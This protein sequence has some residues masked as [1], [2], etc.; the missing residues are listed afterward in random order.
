MKLF[1]VL[2][3][4]TL[5]AC[6][7]L[8]EVERLEKVQQQTQRKIAWLEHEPDRVE[9]WGSYKN[10]CSEAGWMRW[11]PHAKHCRVN[12]YNRV[13]ERFDWDFM[14]KCTKGDLAT[15]S[16]CE[17]RLSAR[18]TWNWRAKSGNN[19]ICVGKGCA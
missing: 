13:P 9:K 1:L 10:W 3:L 18:N 7:P 14:Y 11:G 4:A 19:V 15:Q 8:T 5:I 6:A 12:C 16:R 17:D 2:M